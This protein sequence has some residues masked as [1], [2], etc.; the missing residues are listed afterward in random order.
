MKLSEQWLREWVNPP[1]S[2][3]EIAEQLTLAGLEVESVKPVAGYFK[4]VLVGHIVQA[5]PHPNAS[6]LQV[7]QV[8]T[9]E[10]TL[11]SIVCGAAN[12]RVGLKVA[13]ACIG[14]TLPH[15]MTINEVSLR[16]VLSQGMLCSSSEL[17]LTQESEGIL[18]LPDDAPIGQALH[19]YLQ[20]ADQEFSIRLTPNRGDCLSVKGLARDLAALTQQSI[21]QPIIPRLP[22]DIPDKLAIRV[23]SAEACPHYVGRIIRGINQHAKTP[24]WMRERLRRSGFR[25]IH[26]VVDVTNYV[27]LEL[28]QPLHAFDL[29]RLDSEMVVRWARAGEKISL[30]DGKAVVLDKDTF[31]VADKTQVH[32][33]AGVMGGSFSAVSETSSDIFLESAFFKP[34]TLAGRARQY[35]LT[36]ESAYRFERGVDP[37]I[38]VE[39]I[40]RATQLLIEIVG[41]KIGPIVACEAEKEERSPILLRQSRVEKLLGISLHETEI[42]AILQRL[43][44]TFARSATEKSWQVIAPTWRFDVTREADLIEELVRIHGYSR[45]PC[46]LS[47]VPLKFLPHS[48]TE[49]PLKR[50]YDLLVDRDY[51]EVITYSFISPQL[52]HAITPHEVPLTL[53]NPISNELSVM[54]SS[55]W[56]GLLQAVM[57]NQKRQQTRVRLFETGLC[58]QTRTGELSQGP[59]LAV[60]ATG[61]TVEEQWGLA[62]TPIDFF[63]VKADIEAL[64]RLS[65]Q[66]SDIEFIPQ[67]HPALHPGQASKIVQRGKEIGYGGAL[68]PKLLSELDLL[69]PVY[70]FEL[71]LG[72]LTQ[73]NLPCFKPFSKFPVVRR[74]ISFWVNE[75]FSAQ[76]ILKRAR[77][78][79]GA[80]LNDIYLFDVYH[81]Q[82][83]EKSKRSLALALLWQ[84]PSRTLIDAEIDDL[85]HNVIVDLEQ[86][87]TIQLRE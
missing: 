74:D 58:F 73:K 56:P 4:H 20:L 63:T 3:N 10:G 52:Q 48:D 62:K 17:G 41:G 81:D 2:S 30:L 66:L 85:L 54:R 38:T 67:A 75:K 72:V 71:S 84:H 16:G 24:L 45:I 31:V 11:L 25:S 21:H 78:Q 86:Q 79:A 36:S 6:R 64:L 32:A 76:T 7:C 13:V 37:A 14:A 50:V 27:L 49:L 80:W 42:E 82:E 43:G 51:R 5:S 69:G 70:L 46:S 39:A 68:H 15:D 87:F 23:K 44:M 57:Y 83:K 59:Q 33:I 1:L 35:G 22:A 29:A 53:V 18:E 60:I 19:A 34:A 65:G 47:R 77:E 8:D 28:G 40:E 9:G 12:A 55:L 61:D 26:P